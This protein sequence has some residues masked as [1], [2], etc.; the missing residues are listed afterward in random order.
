MINQNVRLII[1]KVLIL[2][3]RIYDL[4]FSSAGTNVHFPH[5]KVLLLKQTN[6]WMVCFHDL[7]ILIAENKLGIKF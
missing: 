2:Y 6:V 1:Q 3:S 5:S 7:F 4:P